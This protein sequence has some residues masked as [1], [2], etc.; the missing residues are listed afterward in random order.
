MADIAG[1]TSQITNRKATGKGADAA[2][3]TGD[4]LKK[5]QRLRKACTDFEA[6]FYY[7]VFKGMRQTIPQSGFL[8]EAPGKDTYNM[9]FDQRVAE[10]LANKGEK[11]GLQQTLFEQLNNR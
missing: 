10:E 7:Y 9:I 1:I 5:E 2:A 6:I 3:A 11:T 4:S 8:K